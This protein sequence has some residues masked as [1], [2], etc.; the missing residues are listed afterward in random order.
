M[1]NCSF[2]GRI[3]ADPEL[4]R[5]NSGLDVCS[6]HIAV[7]RPGSKERKAD[8]IPVVAWRQTAEFICRYFKKGQKIG[9]TG[10][11]VGRE[12]ED[13][14]KQKRVSLE[15]IVDR[16][17]FCEKSENAANAPAPAAPAA[18]T[19]S[20]NLTPASQMGGLES[21]EELEEDDLPF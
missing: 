14:Y 2:I 5:T 18:P 3:T 7:D 6:F 16:A 1:N 13:K 15:L 12:W 11:M 17:E 4:K 10:S 21:F 9:V 8:F 19:A 20:Y